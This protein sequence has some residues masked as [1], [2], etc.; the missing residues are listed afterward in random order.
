MP[1][2][3]TQRWLKVSSRT[4]PYRQCFGYSVGTVPNL[5]KVFKKKKYIALW[6]VWSLDHFFVF[7]WR[8]V[9]KREKTEVWSR[10][11]E[12]RLTLVGIFSGSKSI[13]QAYRSGFYFF[14]KTTE[15][16]AQDVDSRWL[17]SLP[18]RLF[19]SHMYCGTQNTIKK[20]VGPCFSL[21]LDHY[22]QYNYIKMES[23]VRIHIK[24]STSIK[25]G[26]GEKTLIFWSNSSK[27]HAFFS[28][29]P[30]KCTKIGIFNLLATSRT[31]VTVHAWTMSSCLAIATN[32]R[33]SFSS[34]GSR[35]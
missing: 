12:H 23:R 19:H 27:K 5:S 15:K 8:T 13:T 30:K 34:S 35:L 7:P 17:E 10:C 28:K 1:Y 21:R 25:V 20:V 6:Y 31:V 29:L 11:H 4:I 32:W 22:L 3:F 9:E 18:V 33:A 2:A 24:A 16:F 26:N 14:T